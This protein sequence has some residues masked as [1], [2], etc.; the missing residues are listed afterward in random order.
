MRRILHLVLW[1]ALMA[2][3][4]GCGWVNGK[5]DVDPAKRATT[6][7]A[8]DSVLTRYNRIRSQADAGVDAAPLADVETGALLAID[9]GAF[10]LRQRLSVTTKPFRFTRTQLVVAGRFDSYP[11]WFATLTRAAGTDQKVAAVFARPTSTSPWLLV[12]AP[13]LARSTELGPVAQGDDGSA[14]IL[15]ADG[16][17]WSDGR[18]VERGF[19]QQLVDDYAAT[20][21]DP[22]GPTASR[23]VKDSFISQ[24]STLAQAQPATGVTFEQQWSAMPVRHAV[25]L[26]DGGA[27]VF[28]TLVR[29]D[30]YTVQGTRSLDFAGSEAGAYFPTPVTRSATL[31]YRH[32]VLMLVPADGKPLVIGQYGGLTSASGS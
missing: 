17:Q 27:L 15:A 8:A 2:A 32:Q 10:Y 9:R 21:A 3:L 26:S 20:L 12:E 7:A 1:L 5:A 24:M 16:A 29:T 28:A 25:R 18:T 13:R 6:L 30:R 22:D 23:F 31:D 11:L 19:P 4:A 14:V